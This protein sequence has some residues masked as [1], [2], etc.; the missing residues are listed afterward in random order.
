MDRVGRLRPGVQSPRSSPRGS[1]S[2]A[3][4]FIN[5]RSRAGGRSRVR[6]ERCGVAGVVADG[7]SASCCAA[8]LSAALRMRIS[9]WSSGPCRLRPRHPSCVSWQKPSLFAPKKEN[10][11]PLPVFGL[12]TA[13]PGFKGG[14]K[15]LELS[16]SRPSSLTVFG[17]NRRVA[18]LKGARKGLG[19]RNP[20]RA[21]RADSGHPGL[22]DSD[23]RRPPSES[24]AR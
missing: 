12:N 15:G 16:R 7:I 1:R 6:S 14:A 9:A 23:P 18:P 5:A 10:L 19:L 3:R 13:I 21:H 2:W 17:L 20:G 11:A 4:R 24:H 8:I 22:T